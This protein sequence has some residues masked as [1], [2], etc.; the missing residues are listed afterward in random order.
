MRKIFLIILLTIILFSVAG[1]VQAEECETPPCTIIA[2]PALPGTPDPTEGVPQFIKYIFVFSLGIVGLVGLIAIIIAGFK[3]VTSVGD[4]N[5]AAEA[6]GG[7]SSALLGILLL[8]GSYL[9]LN[10]I[11]PDLLKLKITGEKAWIKVEE[12][13]EPEGC[14]LVSAQWDKPVIRVYS[15]EIAATAT[16]TFTLSMA[17][18]DEEFPFLPWEL[19]KT[20]HLRQIRDNAVDPFCDGYF[21]TAEKDEKKEEG[22]EDEKPEFSWMFTFYKRYSN[23]ENDERRCRGR[24]YTEMP[25]LQIDW[26]IAEPCALHPSDN[27]CNFFKRKEEQKGQET[28]FLAGSIQLKEDLPI[29]YV[30]RLKITGEDLDDGFCCK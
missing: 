26:G 20:P 14:R 10:A 11:N 25:N 22:E 29:Q 16:V 15:D 5:K 17:C 13:E 27:L 4:P 30:P 1:F 21:H 24:F 3:Y 7:I 8:L 6:K 28:F 12:E 18:K 19:A 23:I 9:I 2:Y